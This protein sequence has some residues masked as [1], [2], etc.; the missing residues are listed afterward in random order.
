MHNKE[1][2][3]S[4]RGLKLFATGSFLSEPK[5]QSETE[6]Q[7]ETGPF[8]FPPSEETFITSGITQHEPSIDVSDNLEHTG[9]PKRKNPWLCIPAAIWVFLCSLL[10]S[11]CYAIEQYDKSEKEHTRVTDHAAA[12]AKGGSNPTDGCDVDKYCISMLGTKDFWKNLCCAECGTPF[13]GLAT[14]GNPNSREEEDGSCTCGYF[15]YDNKGD[16]LKWQVPIPKM[17]KNGRWLTLREIRSF[18]RGGKETCSEDYCKFTSIITKYM[19]WGVQC[20]IVFC[21][22]VNLTCYPE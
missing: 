3:T 20:S 15:E 13:K 14:P 21:F 17:T 8:S 12:L 4:K 2:T 7:N 18:V 6:F 11:F 16:G 10:P 9:E 5:F 22:I 1:P 19:M